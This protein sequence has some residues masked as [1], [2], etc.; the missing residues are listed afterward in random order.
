MS[1]D[2][3]DVSRAP[4][5]PSRDRLAGRVAIITG[6]ARG[7][8]RAIAEAYAAE[9]CAIVLGDLLLDEATAAS[10]AIRASGGTASAVHVDVRSIDSAD[11][12]AEHALTLTGAIDVLVNN[13]AIYD[14]LRVAPLESLT[15][16]EWDDVLSVNVRGVWNATRAVVPAMRSRGYGKIIN[17]ASGTASQGTP[18]H[19]HYVASKGAVVA[20]TRAMSRELGPDG[21]RVNALAP[22]LTESGARKR[23]EVAPDR[24]PPM[25]SGALSGTLTPGDL[26]G[27]ALFLASGES[28]AMTGQVVA[29]NLGTSFVG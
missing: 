2:R 29:V 17:L 13:A 20:M 18:F 22:G 10:D 9:G 16:D 23:W 11:E 27:A 8:G 7:I 24:R 3:A 5:G 14:G 21:I 4:D 28:D 19:L 6:G 12:L 1:G 25:P 26:T 15:V